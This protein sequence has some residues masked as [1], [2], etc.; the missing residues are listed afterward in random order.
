MT[1]RLGRGL[2]ELIET[3]T[4]TSG[5]FVSLRVDQIKTGRYQPR[6]SMDVDTGGIENFHQ[7]PRDH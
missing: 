6:L 3:A 1:K 7:T 2:A 5:N 4:Q